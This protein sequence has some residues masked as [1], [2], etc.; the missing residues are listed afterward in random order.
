MR[1]A[2]NRANRA[3]HANRANRTDP[4]TCPG[5]SWI[6]RAATVALYEELA[7]APK[8]GLVSFVDNGSHDDM[9]AQTFM[10]SLFALRRYFV[11]IAALGERH[12]SLRELEAA[13]I[14][15]EGRVLAATGGVNT[16]R[17]AVFTLGLVCA[18][19][20]ALASNTAARPL[21]EQIP[22]LLRATLLSHWGDALE[23]RRHRKSGLPGGLAARRH[24]LRGASDEAA[25]GL[26]TLFEIAVPAL[27]G[28]RRRGL[29]ATQAGIETLFTV[30]STLDDCNLAHRGGLAGLRYAQ[31]AARRWLEAGGAPADVGFEHA[32]AIHRDF[33]SRRLSPGGSADLL[34]AACLVER[35]SA[36]C[37]R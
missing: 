10:R 21:A 18:A 35:I 37:R 5:P 14:E 23:Q 9:D 15:A 34:S 13:G 2:P 33:V 1:G 30:M 20:G 36:R 29:S 26:P 4:A 6:G 19:A 27:S 7:L 28:A 12:A 8:P 3:V 17:G 32:R 16:Q 11:A 22:A 25:L 31:A 24:G